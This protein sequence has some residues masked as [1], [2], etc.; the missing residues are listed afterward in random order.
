[1]NGSHAP[2]WSV[3]IISAGADLWVAYDLAADISRYGGTALL[4]ELLSSSAPIVIG[5]ISSRAYSGHWMPLMR[6]WSS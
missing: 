3:F 2:R 4:D 1:M 6:S 5:A